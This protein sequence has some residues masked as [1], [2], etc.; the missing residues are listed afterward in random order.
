MVDKPL[1]DPDRRPCHLP[2]SAALIVDGYAVREKTVVVVM[3]AVQRRITPSTRPGMN[4]IAHDIVDLVVVVDDASRDKT[5]E[6]AKSLK[7]F[8]A[9]APSE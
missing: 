3:P 7:T 5:F 8:W 6:K 4:W 1:P 9:F 2:G